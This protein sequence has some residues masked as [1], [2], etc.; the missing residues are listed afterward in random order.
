[1]KQIDTIS[2]E[3]LVTENDQ[4][5]KMKHYDDVRHYIQ[6]KQESKFAKQNQKITSIETLSNDSRFFT[7]ELV[8]N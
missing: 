2:Q 1:M 3:N 6:V 7:E 5:T 4:S 8:T